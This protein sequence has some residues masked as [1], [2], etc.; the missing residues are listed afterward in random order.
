[1]FY[2]NEASISISTIWLNFVIFSIDEK[3]RNTF[4]L[5]LT[6]KPYYL[7]LHFHYSNQCPILPPPEWEYWIATWTKLYNQ[8]YYKIQLNLFSFSLSIQVRLNGVSSQ[9][10]DMRIWSCELNEWQQIVDFVM[11]M[12]TNVNQWIKLKGRDFLY[13]YRFFIV[14]RDSFKVFF[15]I[16]DNFHFQFSLMHKLNVNIDWLENK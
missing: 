16:N 12:N 13:S 11:T 10:W 3:S 15:I 14:F 2:Y 1:M 5:S 7:Y 4:L 8:L 6:I 9:I